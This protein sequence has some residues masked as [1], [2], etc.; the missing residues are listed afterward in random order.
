M[1]TVFLP[2]GPLSLELSTLFRR[3]GNFIFFTPW[4]LVTPSPLP[5]RYRLYAW[6]LR[7]LK[8]CAFHPFAEILF[9]S[10]ATFNRYTVIASQKSRRLLTVDSTRDDPWRVALCPLVRPS[11][12]EIIK[13]SGNAKNTSKPLHPADREQSEYTP[14]QNPGTRKAVSSPGLYTTNSEARKHAVHLY[15]CVFVYCAHTGQAVYQLAALGRFC[16]SRETA[17]INRSWTGVW[18][19]APKT[20]NIHI[21]RRP[22]FRIN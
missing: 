11:N 3:I 18:N 5:A 10:F 17:S 16:R 6:E 8:L 4:F 20:P 19:I 9:R 2:H 13:T 1:H 12:A 21:R 22:M 15:V 14:G 7:S